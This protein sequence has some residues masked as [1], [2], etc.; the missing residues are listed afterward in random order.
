MEQR[1]EKMLFISKLDNLALD[2]IT[3]YFIITLCIPQESG[4]NNGKELVLCR[5]KK[6]FGS[7]QLQ[8]TL[9]IK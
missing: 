7:G 6:T 9:Y 2:C 4:I 1:V 3:K 5:T 8:N